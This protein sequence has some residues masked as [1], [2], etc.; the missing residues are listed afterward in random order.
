[1][2]DGSERENRNVV[3]FA[4]GLVLG[5]REVSSVVRYKLEDAR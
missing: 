5:H 2:P 4:G 3:V 1:L